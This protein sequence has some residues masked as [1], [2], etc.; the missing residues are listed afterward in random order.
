MQFGEMQLSRNVFFQG[1]RH[2]AKLHFA[3]L[4]II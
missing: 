1:V 3:K 2:F 4:K